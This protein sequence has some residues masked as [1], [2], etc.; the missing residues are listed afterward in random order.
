MPVSDLIV[1]VACILIAAG[2]SWGVEHPAMPI[3]VNPDD[4]DAYRQRVQPLLD[5]SEEQMLEIIPEQS[6]LYFC[7]CPNCEQGRQEGQFSRKEV[8]TPWSPEDPLVMRCSY[9]GHEYPSNE[10]PM[11][12]VL[13]VTDPAGNTD[14]Y[15]YWE[16]ADGY[17][18]YFGAR[19][20]YHRIRYMERAANSLARMY[21]ITGDDSYARRAALI[22]HRFA[23]VYPGY[24]YHFDYPFREKI[25]YEGDVD[26][27]DFRGGFRTARWTWWA[28]M[29]IPTLLIEAW[30]QI[31]DT[32]AVA[33]LDA[34]ID[35]D[36][37]AE[38]EGFFHT[39][40]RQ[41]M[42]NRD[43]LGNMSPGMWADLIHA[44]RVLGEPE[45]VHTAMGRLERLMTLRF[46]YDGSWEE[47]APSY[48][49]QVVGN[50]D[51]VFRVSSGYSD[52]EGY[53][54][55]ETG[56]RFDNLDIPDAFAVVSRARAFLDMMRLPNG[57]LVPVHDTWSTNRRSA[58]Q[59][60][61]GFLLP[62]LG[63]ACLGRGSGESQF[64][65]HMTWSPGLGHRH[66]DGLSLLLFANGQELLSD[67][68]YTHT[69][70]RAWTLVSASHNTVLVDLENQV[71]DATTYGSLRYFDIT[72]PDCQIVS[73][74]NPEVYPD[75]VTTYRR[76]LAS[77]AIDDERTYLIDR[78]QV[79]GGEQHDYF[80]HGCAD[81]PQTIGVVQAEEI[82]M[83]PLDTLL[84]DGFAFV[85]CQNEGDLGRIDDTAWAYGYLRDLQS[86][87][88]NADDVLTV[89]YASEGGKPTLRAY[90]VAAAGD[91]LVTGRNISVRNAREND[92]EIDDHTRPFA[93]LRRTGGASD[94]V[95]VI[96]PV[97]AASGIE[98]VALLPVEGAAMALEI[99]VPGRRDLI[100]FD[101]DGAHARWLG[102]ELTATAEM[103]VLRADADGSLAATVVDG[104]VNFGDLQARS[105]DGEEHELLAVD[106]N[107][108]ALVVAGDLPASTGAV[109]MLDHA[110]ERVSA[111]EV[112]STEAT[113]GN[114]RITLT[115]D[116]GIE[117]DAA[118]SA[119][120]FAFVPHT[121]HE[122]PHSVRVS[123]VGHAAQ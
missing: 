64:Q 56:R 92:I 10:Y 103:V 108:R 53:A 76:T 83:Q 38:I 78:F 39:A 106:R 50:L 28:Y 72:E 122:G 123:P 59:Q 58:R 48:H 102:R 27:E 107:A 45:Y 60:S 71:A 12:G 80:L 26:P 119:S 114:T 23:E 87:R 20:D 55:P 82:G 18:H 73:V 30:D 100:L 21:L 40:A 17:R 24:C 86:G 25:I 97:G 3:S 29:D 51:G 88:P 68:G 16:N 8:Y 94:F 120:T 15:P 70:G 75:R 110:G 1:C 2:V 89:E 5:L 112:A 52:P 46:F 44:G 66:Y 105:A 79:E 7:D 14:R 19:I 32:E 57:R 116:P 85:P 98:T 67:L 81:E 34:E 65:A 91:Q 43:D 93:M 109:V 69:R 115:S 74:D 31:A 4:L 99:T 47:G 121:T 117:F 42:A 11:E 41:V 90:L 101:A 6:G 118:A 104:D 35:G 36:L 95:S 113:G 84:P 111:Y 9:C 96:E 13:E 63:H 62:A 33:A 77:V 61:E 37:R 54:H 49:S 22:M